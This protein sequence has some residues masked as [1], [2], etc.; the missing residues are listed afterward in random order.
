MD[1]MVSA[2]KSSN[3]KVAHT[4][5]KRPLYISSSFSSFYRGHRSRP[6]LCMVSHVNLTWLLKKQACKNIV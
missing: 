2:M 3:E 4:C 6:F 1:H 5:K